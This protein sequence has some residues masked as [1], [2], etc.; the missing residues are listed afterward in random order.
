MLPIH[1]QTTTFFSE[2]T[3]QYIKILGK[4]KLRLP[5]EEVLWLQAKANYTIVHTLEGKQFLM[6]RTLKTF[7]DSLPAFIRPNQSSLV[8]RSYVIDLLNPQTLLL[9]NGRRLSISRRK[10]DTIRKAFE[11]EN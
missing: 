7:E 3:M 10:K 11:R 1:E 2:M 8:N 5:L 4:E 9:Q 6:A